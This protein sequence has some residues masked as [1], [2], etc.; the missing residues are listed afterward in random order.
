MEILWLPSLSLPLFI[1]SFPPSLVCAA[2]VSGQVWSLV[3]SEQLL[4]HKLTT[5][6]SNESKLSI[7]LSSHTS[8]S[9]TVTCV[10]APAK[11][12][13]IKVA[14]KVLPSDALATKAAAQKSVIVHVSCLYWKTLIQLP[15]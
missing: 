11:V 7:T 14:E 1:S 10:L 3:S 2:S 8:M 13:L 4:S 9:S 5:S 15:S 12:L 6:S